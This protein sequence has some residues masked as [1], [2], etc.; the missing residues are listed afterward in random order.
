LRERLGSVKLKPPWAEIELLAKIEEKREI[1]SVLEEKD[2]RIKE[3][4]GELEK[5]RSLIAEMKEKLAE[6]GG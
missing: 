2:A 3:L 5:H 6:K 1:R 4:E